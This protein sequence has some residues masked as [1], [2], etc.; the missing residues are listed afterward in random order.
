MTHRENSLSTGSATEIQQAATV[1]LTRDGSKGIEVV[2]LLRN[3]SSVF[4]GNYYVFPG[5]TLHERDSYPEAAAICMHMTDEEASACLGVERGG[6]AYWHAAIRECF[7]ESG[8]LLA[9]DSQGNFISADDPKSLVRFAA[10]RKAVYAGEI[11]LMDICNREG[12]RLATDRLVYLSHRITP[13]GHQRRYDTRFFVGR[14][15]LHQKVIHDG[16]ETVAHVWIDPAEALKRHTR[17]EFN[18]MRPTVEILKILSEIRC[19]Y[20]LISIA[21]G[22]KR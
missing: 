12:L 18:L 19:T 1:V 15:P 6:M 10:Y 3:A 20:E 2:L 7:E 13:D 14:A 5:G 17:G 21:Q 4:A 22:M 9:V 8:L 11:E 16:F